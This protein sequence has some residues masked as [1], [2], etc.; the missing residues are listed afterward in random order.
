MCESEL[1]ALVGLAEVISNLIMRWQCPRIANCKRQSKIGCPSGSLFSHCFDILFSRRGCA[2]RH[3][4]ACESVS[5]DAI[6][7]RRNR[8][9]VY[10]S[11]SVLVDSRPGVG[12]MPDYEPV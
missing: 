12:T 7:F 3:R 4:V 11:D 8:T 2:H 6:Q 9:G 10:F 5:P 1:I